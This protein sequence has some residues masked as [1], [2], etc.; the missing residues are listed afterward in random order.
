V[1]S[2]D[3]E[4]DA[5]IRGAETLA[6]LLA[7]KG[8]FP[9]RAYG[10]SGLA[11]L[12]LRGAGPS[13]VA[14]LLDGFPVRNAQLG[15]FDLSLLPA[16]L[17]GSVDVLAGSASA[18]YGTGAIGGVVHASSRFALQVPTTLTVGSGA[19][20]ERFT[21][22]STG[23]VRRRF[24]VGTAVRWAQVDGDFR[25]TNPALLN[26]PVVRR[27]NADRHDLAAMTVF[28]LQGVRYDADATFIG[29]QTTRGLP[30]LAHATPAGERQGDTI[31]RGSA[32]VG[33]RIRGL[34]LSAASMAD[35]SRIRYENPSLGIA[36]TGVVS[37][38]A[39]RLEAQ[40]EYT[41]GELERRD[42]TRASFVMVA[43][44]ERSTAEH[45]ELIGEAARTN[46]ALS[47]ASIFLAGS[48]TAYPALRFDAFDTFGNRSALV[49]SPRLGLNLRPHG[50]SISLKA[51]GGRSFRMPTF[52]DLFWRDAGA[53]GNLELNPERSWSAEAGPGWFGR[54]ASAEASLFIRRTRDRI[55]WVADERQ[56]WSPVNVGV[57]AARGVQI[58]SLAHSKVSARF[59]GVAI[60]VKLNY[61]WSRI[62]DITNRAEGE[63]Y[64]RYTPAHV[65]GS[66]IDLSA[67]AFRAGFTVSASST[68]RITS[69]GGETLPGYAV[70]D[71][72]IGGTIVLGRFHADLSVGI[73]N[74][75]DERYSV[76]QG[77]PMPPRHARIQLTTTI[78]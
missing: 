38:A 41:R 9:V 16:A 62:R 22:G 19:F 23:F 74:L 20:G 3:A 35:Q 14:I 37:T 54:N 8:G 57:V 27:K 33:F 2:L 76:I 32:S 60:S 77:Y 51:S 75:L 25:Y 42:P 7:K 53:S 59:G 34:Q 24:A 67:G 55:V 56:T 45:P 21:G 40:T 30:G 44:V 65:G 11:T 48:L 1:I 18:L 17:L 43:D 13:Q 6:D 28:S 5:D 63:Q 46:A 10:S 29:I 4:S 50:G 73:Q 78:R 12:S 49:L 36:Q 31:L 39:L 69:D 26:A 71:A 72:R 61:T 52:N 15:Q 47:V 70:V 64:L 66:G 68:R 58:H